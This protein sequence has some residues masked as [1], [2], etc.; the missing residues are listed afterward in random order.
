MVIVDHEGTI[1][2]VNAQAERM[3]GY[4]RAELLGQHVELLV[5]E[6]Y[7]A[8]H[9]QHRGGYF[10][11]A[12]PRPMGAGLELYGRRKDGAEFP[13]EISLSPLKTE[14]GTLV[15]S[16]IRDITD[17]KR[18]ED[19]RVRLLRERAAHE[20]ATRIKD[21]FIAT[22]SHE[23]RTPLNAILGWA[24]L[25]ESGT[26]PAGEMAHGLSAIRRNAK[27]QAQLIED[28][29]DVSRIVTGKLQLRNELVDLAGV[30]ESAVEVMRPAA[31][32]KHVALDV[33]M[34]LRPLLVHG[35]ANRL[36]QAVW[37]VL[38]NAIKFTDAHGRV[39]VNLRASA[40]ASVLTIRD[41]GR[42][43][44]P[45]FIPYIFDRFRQADSSYSR[46]HGG[47]GLGLAIA[48]SI[49]ELHGG[50]I[51]AHSSGEGMGA[52]FQLRLPLTEIVSPITER[53]AKRSENVPQLTGVRVLVVDDQPDERE[54]MLAVLTSL[55]AVVTTAE[56]AD[57]A[58]AAARTNTYDI[59]ISD[60]AMPV[61]DGYELLRQLRREVPH[62]P[63]MALTAHARDE[64]QQR[65]LAAG[66]RRY[67]SK[68]V[69]PPELARAVASLVP[70]QQR[71]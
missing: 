68:P 19:E 2:L 31:A 24:T 39:D 8:V 3:F 66:F 58:L 13:V 37:N 30:V 67:L 49:V 71:H 41:T 11:G 56:S 36:Q 52:T 65:A 27:A 61:K 34:E 17:R 28:L 48:K 16:A 59:V 51:S 53:H 55:G 33:V 43:M 54:L 20:E 69:E 63:V 29:L 22:L 14:E 9:R 46:Q 15:A 62:V 44:R 35:D 18:I 50:S 26:L 47:L 5:P 38:S 25:I 10:K 21:E 7:R 70:S 42:G 23:L 6:R 12:H 45:E 1:V 4:P 32:A 57:A 40:D 64:D 60:L